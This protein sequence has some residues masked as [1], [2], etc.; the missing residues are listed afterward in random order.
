M[1]SQGQHTHLYKT[2]P[3]NLQHTEKKTVRACKLR[4]ILFVTRA[5]PYDETPSAAPVEYD[6]HP[7]AVTWR[8]EANNTPVLSGAP[9]RKPHRNRVVETHHTFTE[10]DRYGLECSSPTTRRAPAAA[11]VGDVRFAGGG[12]KRALKALTETSLLFSRQ[13]GIL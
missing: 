4:E 12:S 8:G 13:S 5:S 11:E 3:P 9:P 7:F 6:N 10:G 2:A 1:A